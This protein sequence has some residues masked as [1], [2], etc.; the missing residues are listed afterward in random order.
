MPPDW[1]GDVDA[2]DGEPALLEGV[3][4]RMRGVATQTSPIVESS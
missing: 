2:D 4:Q 1:S 3:D